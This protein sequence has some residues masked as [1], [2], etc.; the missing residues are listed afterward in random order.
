M[1]MIMKMI[2]I[3][4]KD[5]IN[6]NNNKSSGAPMYAHCFKSL[7]FRYLYLSCLLLTCRFDRKITKMIMMMMMMMR[8]RRRRRI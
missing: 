7:L 6:N 5:S 1:K 3:K 4:S 8:R 2:L